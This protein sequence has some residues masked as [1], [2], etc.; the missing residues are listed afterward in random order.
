MVRLEVG[1]EVWLN[2]NILDWNAEINW[3]ISDERQAFH[4]WSELI[5]SRRLLTTGRTLQKEKDAESSTE[6]F[7][8]N[9]LIN[10]RLS[11]PSDL[12]EVC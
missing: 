10:K 4:S 9:I 11:Y 2:L 3:A 12:F 7:Q 8:I 6:L 5:H 1:L